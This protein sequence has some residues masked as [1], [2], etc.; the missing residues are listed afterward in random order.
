MIDRKD[1]VQGWIPPLSNDKELLK[2]RIDFFKNLEN[3]T[4]SY[5]TLEYNDFINAF[6]NSLQQN[7]SIS[8]TGLDQFKQKD[9]IIGCQHFIDELIMTHGLE[10][11]QLFKGGYNYYKKLDSNI[12]Y[13]TLE[14]LQKG[15]PLILEYPFPAYSTEHP[16]Y[17]EIIKKCNE[18]EIDLYLDCAWLPSAWDLQLNLNQTCIK[19]IAISL[20]KCFGLHWSR[21]GVRWSRNERKDSI[22][23]QN[24]H[25]MISIPNLMIG[26]Y[27]LDR[28]PMDY[29]VQKYKTKYHEICNE[30]NLKAG[31]IILAAN[32]HDDGTLYGT[33]NLL[34]KHYEK[35]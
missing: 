3:K 27:Y 12:K 35:N 30:L 9:V 10:N 31:K 8:I 26:K 29:L 18:L 21:I 23:L 6:E 33:A 20:S 25:R 14:T 19:G 11:I 1:L 32:S 22:W 24:E 2:L 16:Q 17:N 4:Q 13:V 15:K 5:I 7:Q 28:V 34:L